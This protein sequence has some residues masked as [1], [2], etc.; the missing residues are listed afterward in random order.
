MVLRGKTPQKC[1]PLLAG[2]DPNRIIGH[3]FPSHIRIES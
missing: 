1:E 2:L 3:V